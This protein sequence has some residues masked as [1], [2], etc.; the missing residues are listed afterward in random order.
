[1]QSLEPDRNSVLL[2]LAMSRTDR[3]SG[4]HTGN[5]TTHGISGARSGSL[6]QHLCLVTYYVSTTRANGE[7]LTAQLIVL[8]ARIGER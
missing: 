5:G 2:A 8:W 3:I 6:K 1:M 7:S 4:V